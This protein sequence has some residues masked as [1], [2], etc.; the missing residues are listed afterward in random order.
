MTLHAWRAIRDPAAIRPVEIRRVEYSPGDVRLTREVQR[1]GKLRNTLHVVS[2]GVEALAYV[3][4]GG[5]YAAMP[6]P[7]LILLDLNPPRQDGHEVLD[8]VKADTRLESIPVVV[9]T[10][11]PEE[12]D[13]LRRHGL[14][15]CCY[16]AEPIDLDQ[17]NRVVRS[18]ARF[19]LGIMT[20]AH[21]PSSH[22][23][24]PG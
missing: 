14:E 21:A 12:H 22:F 15:A 19:G 20:A 9:L 13:R 8:E 6:R 7:D 18:V 24:R 17:F 1:D 23:R 16:V 3:R 10:T 4:R 11:A 2:D 5:R